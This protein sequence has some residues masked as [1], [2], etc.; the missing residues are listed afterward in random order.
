[1]NAAGDEDAERLNCPGY[2]AVRNDSGDEEH[3]A[4]PTRC[5]ITTTTAGICSLSLTDEENT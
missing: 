3:L 1:M 2:G 4:F 5:I